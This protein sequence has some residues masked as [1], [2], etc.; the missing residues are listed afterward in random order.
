MS[1]T[2][3]KELATGDPGEGY[4]RDAPQQASV[5]RIAA[6]CVHDGGPIEVS[7]VESAPSLRRFPVGAFTSCSARSFGELG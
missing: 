1:I 3:W 2:G 7:L 5:R 6:Q 4:L